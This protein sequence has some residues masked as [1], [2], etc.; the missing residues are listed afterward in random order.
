MFSANQLPMLG[1]N[2]RCLVRHSASSDGRPVIR[3]F[4]SGLGRGG[5]GRF[6]PSKSS[7]CSVHGGDS[8][9]RVSIE[10]FHLDPLVRTLAALWKPL[11]PI[12]VRKSHDFSRFPRD[13]DSLDVPLV[14]AEEHDLGRSVGDSRQLRVLDIVY[15]LFIAVGLYAA[16]TVVPFHGRSVP[17]LAPVPLSRCPIHS[18]SPVHYLRTVPVIVVQVG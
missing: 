4:S 15:A 5:E 9:S 10:R 18:F 17:A 7:S 11:S 8:I 16:R 14:A 12:A 1:A 2:T 6:P 13:L 3:S